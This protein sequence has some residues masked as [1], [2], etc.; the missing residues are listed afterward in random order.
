MTDDFIGS[1]KADWGRQDIETKVTQLRGRRWV[2]P[3]LLAGDIL[4][5]LTLLGFGL[6]YAVVAA[7]GRDPI[8]V[9]SAAAMLLAGLPLALAA[10]RARWRAL[11]WDDETAEGVLRSTI[12]RLKGTQQALKLGLGG[13]YSLFA[14]VILVWAGALAGLIRHPPYILAVI[15]LSW[16]VTAMASLWWI[17]RR[18]ARLAGE[19]AQCEALL[20][21][22][23]GV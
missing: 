18:L 20:R 4:G 11:A 14:L 21:Q 19:R 2:G 1:L 12:G 3:A 8:Y 6:G 9:L 13:A 7:K 15:T 23:E 5:V 17:W 16:A 22:F 10:L